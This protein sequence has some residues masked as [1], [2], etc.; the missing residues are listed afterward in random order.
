M[1]EKQAI[2]GRSKMHLGETAVLQKV[3][4]SGEWQD[5]RCAMAGVLSKS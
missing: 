3:T 2:T 5:A 1:H 4:E